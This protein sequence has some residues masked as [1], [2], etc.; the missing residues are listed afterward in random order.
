MAVLPDTPRFDPWL[1]GLEVVS[2]AQQLTDP[3]GGRARLG[4]VL[5]GPGLALAG[6]RR[7]GGYSRGML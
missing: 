7:V 4:E 5:D 2:L 6:R 1:T 3:D